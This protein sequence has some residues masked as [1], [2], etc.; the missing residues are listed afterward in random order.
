MSGECEGCKNLNPNSAIYGAMWAT[1]PVFEANYLPV[2]N[3]IENEGRGCYSCLFLLRV[4]DEFVQNWR[5]KKDDISFHVIAP[6]R[7]PIEVRITEALPNEESLELANVH[8]SAPEGK[9][10][11]IRLQWLFVQAISKIT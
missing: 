10:N 2:V 9:I 11:S 4:I 6:D 1:G 7:R 3:I 5:T 8:L